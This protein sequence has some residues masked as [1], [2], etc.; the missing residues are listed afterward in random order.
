MITI[1]NLDTVD[2]DGIIHG[3]V[4]TA[5]L[6]NKDRAS[7]IQ[8]ALFDFFKGTLAATANAQAERDAAI[9]K[10]EA[11]LAK[12]SDPAATK[13]DIDA[14]ARKADSERQREELQKQL[15]SV[16]AQAADIQT[17]IDDLGK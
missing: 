14:E 17:K 6:A 13:E 11:I 5:T 8:S 3:D 12:A 10:C 9:K 4:V 7:E 16:N 15:D 1:Q 2:I